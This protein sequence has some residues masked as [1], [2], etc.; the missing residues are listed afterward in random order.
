MPSKPL[1]HNVVGLYGRRTINDE[2]AWRVRRVGH[3]IGVVTKEHF[4]ARASRGVSE[5][6][7]ISR[8]QSGDVAA[9]HFPEELLFACESEI[10][11]GSPDAQGTGE[12]G[13]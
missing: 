4:Y 3:Y 7:L 9:H 1:L 12:I 13:E 2:T 6:V 11:T 5:S 10:K 8:F